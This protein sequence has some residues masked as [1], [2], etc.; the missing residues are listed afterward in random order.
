MTRRTVALLL[1]G[2]MTLIGCSLPPAPVIRSDIQ[3]LGRHWVYRVSD[4]QGQIVGQVD[5]KIVAVDG[6]TV[7]QETTETLNGVTTTRKAIATFQ[8]DGSL[9]VDEGDGKVTPLP[10]LRKRLAPGASWSN[11]DGTTALVVGQET[12]SVP[13]GSY[14]AFRL[15]LTKGDSVITEWF[16]PSVGLIKEVSK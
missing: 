5:A 6:A 9:L 2:A 8:P 3:P 7:T 1:A 10:S 14:F 13:A 15:T 12:I 4:P 16:Y 11:P